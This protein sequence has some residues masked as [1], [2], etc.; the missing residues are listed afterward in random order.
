[1]KKIRISPTNE[2][3][4]IPPIY[5][6][7]D[8]TTLI[9]GAYH[10]YRPHTKFIQYLSVMVNSACRQNGWYHQCGFR[11]HINKNKNQAKQK[12]S[13]KFISIYAYSFK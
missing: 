4:I 11:Q 12:Q 7:R 1:V 6:R 13:I 5:R 8:K 3:E 9:M 10:C 2:G